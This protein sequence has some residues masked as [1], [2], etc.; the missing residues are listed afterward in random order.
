[1]GKDEFLGL[2]PL[3]FHPVLGTWYKFKIYVKIYVIE[4][5]NHIKIHGYIEGD[6][7]KRTN[8]VQ[9]IKGFPLVKIQENGSLLISVMATDKATTDPVAGK[10]LT[11]ILHEFY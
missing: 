4:L 10:L 7:E 9:Q 8:Y 11:N 2:R 1:M 6:I 5:A 3:N